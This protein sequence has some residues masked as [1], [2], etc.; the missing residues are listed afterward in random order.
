M[1]P[2]EEEGHIALHLSVGRSVD[3]NL[4]A[5][6]LENHVPDCNDISYVDWLW[7]VEEPY[8]F[9]GQKVKVIPLWTYEETVRSIFW[10][11]LVEQTSSLVQ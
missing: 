6:Y 4:S 2:F 11:S 5:H 9:S 7:V 10:E 3:H 8:R 1:P